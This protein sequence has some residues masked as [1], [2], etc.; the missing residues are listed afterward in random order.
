M[1]GTSKLLR[2]NYSM[3]RSTLTRFPKNSGCCFIVPLNVL[4][5]YAGDL[6]LD[7]QIRMKLKET[8]QETGRLKTSREAGRLAAVAFPKSP[9]PALSAAAAVQTQRFHRQK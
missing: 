9:A 5:T 2:G 6:R 3:R 7:A 8:F 4:R 1:R